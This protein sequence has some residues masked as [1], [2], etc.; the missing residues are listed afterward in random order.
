[1]APRAWFATNARNL[2]E[3]RKNGYVPSGPV[4]VSMIGGDYPEAADTLYLREDMPLDRMDWRMLVDVEVHLWANRTVP[5]GRA[6]QVVAAIASA[7]PARLVLRLGTHGGIV[8][9]IEVGDGFHIRAVRDIPAEHRFTW[10]PINLT[11]SG[12]GAKLRRALLA[13]HPAFTTL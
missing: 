2:L 8:H 11:G 5:L 1:M 4:V 9:D 13:Q 10:C 6:Q 12:V 3:S 7:R